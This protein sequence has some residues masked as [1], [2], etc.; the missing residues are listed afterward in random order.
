LLKSVNYFVIFHLSYVEYCLIKNALYFT[1]LSKKI[2][3]INY[4]VIFH[5]NILTLSRIAL[6]PL[7]VVLYYLQPAYTETPIF[8]WINFS[9]TGVY[10]AISMTDYLDGYFNQ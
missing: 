1:P 3:N 2:Q 9:V 5:P 6:I 8:T 4:F 10:A 7:F